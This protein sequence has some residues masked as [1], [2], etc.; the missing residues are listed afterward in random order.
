PQRGDPFGKIRV[1]FA[2][3][4]LAPWQHQRSEQDSDGDTPRLPN[5]VI[6]ER[7]F[8]EIRDRDEQSHDSDA[9]KPASGNQ[10]L[11]IQWRCFSRSVNAVQRLGWRRPGR[12]YGSQRCFAGRRRN[13]WLWRH[14]SN[15]SANANLIGKVLRQRVPGD[16]DSPC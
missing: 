1:A 15:W 6:V 13:G 14:C 9:V 8:E 2:E 7:K 4:P 5:P 16:L 10:T 12:G 11:K 3:Q